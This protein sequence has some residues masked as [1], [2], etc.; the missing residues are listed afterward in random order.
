MRKP[1]LL[2]AP[3]RD[4]QVS[5]FQSQQMPRCSRREIPASKTTA[6]HTCIDGDDEGHGRALERRHRDDDR[7]RKSRD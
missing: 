1:D 4:D 6:A 5:A 7:G 3:N 2:E